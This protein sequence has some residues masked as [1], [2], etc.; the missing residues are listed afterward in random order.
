MQSCISKW[1][2]EMEYPSQSNQAQP[3]RNGCGFY[4][5]SKNDGMCSICYK[6]NVQKNNSDKKS[7]GIIIFCFL[8]LCKISGFS[9]LYVFKMSGSCVSCNEQLNFNVAV[10][11]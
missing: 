6:D 4:G 7:T 1:F 9:F 8:S 11:E 3:C 10:L 5:S 2:S